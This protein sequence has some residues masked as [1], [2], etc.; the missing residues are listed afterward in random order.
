MGEAK[1][2]DFDVLEEALEIAGQTRPKPKEFRYRRPKKPGPPC[3]KCGRP[4]H[5][6]SG[7]L[8]LACYRARSADRRRLLTLHRALKAYPKEEQSNG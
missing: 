6:N 2:R 8:C 7:Q 4:R 1:Q 3:G 5:A